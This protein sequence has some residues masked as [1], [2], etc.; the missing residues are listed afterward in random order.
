MS[1]QIINHYILEC[2][3]VKLSFSRFS[4]DFAAKMPIL[5][6]QKVQ[7]SSKILP[8]IPNFANFVKYRQKYFFFTTASFRHIVSFS[9]KTKSLGAY[10]HRVSKKLCRCYFLNNSVKHWPILILFGTQYRKEN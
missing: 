4:P 2:H 8:Q 10:L 7:I 9:S 6:R 1:W 5:V 3:M